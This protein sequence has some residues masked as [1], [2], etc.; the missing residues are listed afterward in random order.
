M[1][2]TMR[3]LRIVVLVSA[4]L[5][6]AFRLSTFHPKAVQSERVFSRGDA[7]TLQSGQRLKLLNWNLQ[8]MAGKNYV[9]FY[10]EW[11]G[12]GKDDRPSRQ[13]I[14]ATYAE[15]V[16]ILRDEDPDVLILQELHDGSSSTDGEN[17]LER[18][19]SYLPT[20][21]AYYASAFYWK[22]A[23]VPHPRIMGSA[24]MKLAIISKY[25]VDEAYRYQL[26]L[27]PAD[28]V[29][30]HLN[31]KRAVLELRLPVQGGSPLSLMS[32]HMDAFAQGSDTM[33]RQVDYVIGLLGRTA[34]EGRS[35][36][37]GGDFNLVP[38]GLSYSRLPDDE[39][40][41]FQTDTE[42]AKL[43]ALYKGYPRIEDVDGPDG[44][45]FLTHFPNIRDKPDRVLDYF[46]VS[47]DIE[48]QAFAVRQ[49]D[50]LRISDHLPTILEIVVP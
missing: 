14:E 46:F 48:A 23:F 26:P 30:R 50:T 2:K 34:A 38:P 12:S 39:K 32:I 45:R 4:A 11:D 13:D 3:I 22:A 29:T 42:L 8:Y 6:L 49:H 19:L 31:F 21:Y 20:G 40:P 27:M 15:V 36:V 16:R 28:P 17:Q 5:T 47:D 33:Q 25:R 41:M 37:I 43:Y 35:F 7:P 9:F 18:L 24:G 44:E 1:K 10:D